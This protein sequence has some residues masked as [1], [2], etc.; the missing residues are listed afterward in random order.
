V[1]GFEGSWITLTSPILGVRATRQILGGISPNMQEVRNTKFADAVAKPYS[2]DTIRLP[3][4]TLLP[5][6]VDNLLVA[7]RCISAEEEAMGQLRLIPVCS[8][9]GQAAGTAA[10]LALAA[11]IPPAK[12]DVSQLQATLAEQGVDLGM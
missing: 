2:E 12:L 8:A 5:Q 9:T 10:A 6:G 3:Y 7:G 11:G 1:P 4:A